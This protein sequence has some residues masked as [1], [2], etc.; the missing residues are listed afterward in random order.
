[1]QPILPLIG[2]QRQ[3]ADPYL[4]QND[5]EEN[6][7]HFH[8]SLSR[9]LAASLCTAGMLLCTAMPAAATLR[10]TTVKVTA[11]RAYADGNMHIFLS[12][13]TLCA[14]PGSLKIV[15]VG[16]DGADR[17]HATALEALVLGRM[18]DV[19][20]DDQPIGQ[21]CNLTYILAR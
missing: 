4:Y 8:T 13:D 15:R 14:S 18:V 1:M 7:M 16:G 12:D 10:A 3:E 9:I 5:E 17:V 19:E 2:S 21:F 6:V 11:I 20:Y